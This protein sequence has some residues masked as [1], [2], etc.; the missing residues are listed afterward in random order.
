MASRRRHM[1]MNIIHRHR[2]DLRTFVL[3]S[4]C[5]PL[6]D[7]GFRLADNHRDLR[8]RRPVLHMRMRQLFAL[9][10]LPGELLV[11]EGRYRV[12]ATLYLRKRTVLLSLW[13]GLGKHPPHMSHSCASAPQPSHLR[14]SHRHSANSSRR[15]HPALRAA[16]KAPRRLQRAWQCSHLSPCQQPCRRHVPWWRWMGSGCRANTRSQPKGPRNF[17]LWRGP[18]R[19]TSKRDGPLQHG[20]GPGHN[21]PTAPLKT[22]VP[23]ATRFESAPGWAKP[24]IEPSWL[25]EDNDEHKPHNIDKAHIHLSR[26]PQRGPL[27]VL[28]FGRFPPI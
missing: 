24:I 16:A 18:P 21:L 19:G 8:Q 26:F 9:V 5:P 14:S 22:L 23:S 6:M 3:R 25:Q 4:T 28:V 11:V 13:I 17:E 7:D 10:G 27:R 12:A 2:N 1:N 15:G 20:P